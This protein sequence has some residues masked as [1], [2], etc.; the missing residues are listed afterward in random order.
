MEVIRRSKDQSKIRLLQIM[1]TWSKLL[2]TSSN[3]VSSLA[4]TG[5]GLGLQD[6]MLHQRG[7]HIMEEKTIRIAKYL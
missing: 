1:L 6:G 2:S 3:G 7:V 5:V 4:V